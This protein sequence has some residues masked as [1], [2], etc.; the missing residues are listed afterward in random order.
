MTML[1][2]FGVS[3]LNYSNTHTTIGTFQLDALLSEGRD[4]QYTM[5]EF[6]V[7]AGANITD[8]ISAPNT[9]LQLTGVVTG[10]GPGLYQWAISSPSSLLNMDP[11]E[12]ISGDSFSQASRLQKAAALIEKIGDTRQPIT[13]VTGMDAYRDMCITSLH[14]ERKDLRL[15]ITCTLKPLL[16]AEM[17]WSQLTAASTAPKIRGKASKTKAAS[18]KVPAKAPDDGNKKRA[19]SVLAAG[20]GKKV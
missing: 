15:E 20:N 2:G 13:I 14:L 8:F 16:T 17:Q 1:A 19:I 5:T 10:L 11:A 12:A 18:G 9:S 6:A 3:A 7:E 4:R